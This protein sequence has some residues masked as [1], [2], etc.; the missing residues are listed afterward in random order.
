MLNMCVT[1]LAQRI[2]NGEVPETIKNKRVMALDLAQILAGAA[3]RGTCVYTLF[4]LD[5]S[6]E[7]LFHLRP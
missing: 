6:C 1:G 7:H 4:M 2:V 3:H 5:I